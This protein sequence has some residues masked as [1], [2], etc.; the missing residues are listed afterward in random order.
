MSKRKRKSRKR[1][2]DDGASQKSSKPLTPE[3]R[4]AIETWALEACEVAGVELVDVEFSAQGRWI[5]RVF[6]ER[7]GRPGP[8]EGITVDECAEV[9][10]YVEALVDADERVPESYVLE[11]S[12]PGIERPLKKARHY[13]QVLGATVRVVLREAREGKYALDGVLEGFDDAREVAQLRVDGEEGLVEIALADVK[14][15]KVTYDFGGGA[16]GQ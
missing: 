3:V 14:R 15:A 5:V 1:R 13:Q 11:V 16:K 9:S 2:R 12:S 7:P 4:Q 8:G 6:A 10:R